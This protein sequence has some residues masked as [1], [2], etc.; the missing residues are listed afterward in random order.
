MSVITHL[1]HLIIMEP[2]LKEALTNIKDLRG[3]QATLLKD[4]GNLTAETKKTVEEFTKAKN[5]MGSR[6]DSVEDVLRKFQRMQNALKMEARGSFASPVERIARDEVKR[7]ILQYNILKQLEIFDRASKRTQ[8]RLNA[9]V[10]D[11]DEAN[12]PGSTYIANNELERD[13]YDVLASYGAFRNLDVR[14]IGAKTTE[15]RLKTARAAAVFVDEAAAIGADATK[16]GSKVAVTPKKIATLL[17]VSSELIEDDITGVVQDIMNDIAESMAYRVDWI[18]FAA[19]GTADSTDGGFTGMFEGGTAQVAA[20]GNISVATLDYE[21]VLK[22]VT[23]LPVGLLQRGTAKWFINPT[24]LA[25]LLLIKDTTGRPIFQSALE[26]PSYGAIG[27]IFGFPVIPVAAAPSTDS[28]SSK[29]AVFGDASA[30]GVRIR[31][32]MRFDRSEQWA[33]DTD[34][35]TFRGTMRAAAKVKVATAFNVLTTAA[36]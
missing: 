34:E 8:D 21:D 10:K 14:M 31:R 3:D 28:T 6:L 36:S 19:D 2:E 16:A 24:I 35:I 13:I 18:S 12:T 26:A 27:T 20:S 32:D 1:K 23:A 17:S 30:L 25:K 29:L 33:F 15:I 22:C 5:E 9:V 11:L 4:V 7:G